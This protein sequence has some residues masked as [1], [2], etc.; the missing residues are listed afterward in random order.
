ML[1][2]HVYTLCTLNGHTQMRIDSSY[3]IYSKCVCGSTC[4]CAHVYSKC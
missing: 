1:Y 3:N 2:K 4:Q